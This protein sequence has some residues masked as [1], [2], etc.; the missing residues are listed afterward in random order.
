MYM[1]NSS[2]DWSRI[3]KRIYNEGHVVGNHTYDHQDLTGLSADQIK[4]QMKQ[5][6][7]CIFQAIGKRPAFMRPPY[8]S[9]SGNQNVMNALQSAGYTAAVNW[10]VDPMDYSNGGDINYAKQVINQAK[11]QPIITLNHLKYGGATKEGILALAKAE[12]DT[13]LANS[14][15]QLLW[16]NV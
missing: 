5:V 3:I 1:G 13:M 16:K 15:I 6:E 8:G 2:P 4:N 10:N 11:G 14:Y 7:D 9:G 12:I